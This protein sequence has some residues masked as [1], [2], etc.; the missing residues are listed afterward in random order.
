MILTVTLN[1]AVDKTYRT[2]ELLVGYVNRMQSVTNIPGGKGINVSKILCQYGQA[3]TATGFLG[4]HPGKWIEERLREM[5][6]TCGFVTVQGDTRS[7]MNILAANG[8]VTEILEPGPQ[9]TAEER[10][11]FLNQYRKLVQ[12]CELAVLSGSMAPGLPADFYRELITVAG[13]YGKRVILDTS[14]KMLEEGLKGGPYLIKPNRKEL[15]FLAGRRLRDQEDLIEAARALL[16]K[17]TAYAAVS[18]GE[19][20]MYLVGKE[21]SFFA[22]APKVRTVNTVGC[23]DSAVASIAMSLLRG[24]A[25]EVL[26]KKAVAVSA[27]NAAS[28][29]SGSV[30][31]KL[32]EEL[33]E[34]IS[35]LEV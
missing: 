14:D 7:S 21:E 29:V 25:P 30:D 28:L 20:G 34:E 22:A 18:A 9:V 2:E 23:G 10:L 5:G 13:E 12:Q 16:K 8:F 11:L 33:M 1:P 17:D 35:V 4:G 19:R 32:A 6:I 15:E 3:V 27:A 31:Q 24:E 26:L